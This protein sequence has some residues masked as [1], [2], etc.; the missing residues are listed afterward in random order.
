MP[1]ADFFRIEQ[2]ADGVYAAVANPRGF[3]VCNAGIVD[4]GS[5]TL[6]F[7]A[8]LTP[9]A[10]TML[11]RAAERLTHHPV[12]LLVQS[13][14]HGD[15][16]RGTHAVGPA[17]VVSTPRVRELILERGRAHLRSDLE[18]VGP[19]LER[20]R[21]ARPPLPPADL[22]AYEGWF[23]GVLST[24]PEL[25][26]RPPEL[27]FERELVVHGTRRSARILTFGGGHSPSDV[28]VHLPEER[29]VFLGDL[30]SIA[31]HP[32]L[33]DG[34]PQELQRILREVQRLPT[35]RTLPGHGPV[36]PA[37]AVADMERYVTLLLDEARTALARGEG[38]EALP[39]GP[40]PPPFDT[41]KF[42]RFY[43]EN[44]RFVHR[45]LGAARPSG[46]P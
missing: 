9:E 26:F 18:E 23:L 25:V 5:S 15:H 35:D 42:S 46:A 39:R 19:E 29:I 30:V 43:E 36:G 33:M 8:M 32:S 41:W 40:A 1:E 3:G 27:T 38:A 37:G 12:G 45:H 20:L 2:L 44:S 11:A 13:H 34:D 21:S 17:Q 24:S 4:L 31:Y 28:L 22:E 6:V 14:Y 7:D 10:G 16:V